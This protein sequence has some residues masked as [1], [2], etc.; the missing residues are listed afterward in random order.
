MSDPE[1]ARSPSTRPQITQ[2][3]IRYSS[4]LLRLRHIP[5]EGGHHQQYFLQDIQ[6]REEFYF[7]DLQELMGFLQ[8]YAPGFTEGSDW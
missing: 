5:Q 2:P 8:A 3:Q 4:F 6:S 1:I 7:V